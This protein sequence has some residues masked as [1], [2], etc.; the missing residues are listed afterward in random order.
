MLLAT[1]PANGIRRLPD[2]ILSPDE[3]GR[4]NLR[5]GGRSWPIG[6]PWSSIA[7]RFP[8]LSLRGVPTGRDDEA[9]PCRSDHL[10]EVGPRE[11]SVATREGTGILAGAFTVVR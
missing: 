7:G 10:A 4:G 8:V 1:T 11:V 5:E 6:L 3:S 2:V 9:I